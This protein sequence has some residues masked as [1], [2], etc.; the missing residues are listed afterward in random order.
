MP[1]RNKTLVIKDPAIVRALRTPVR[2]EVLAAL[3]A[4][5][6]GSVKDIAGEL[7]RAPA[8]LY[9]H[10][11]ALA[12]AGLIRQTG[13]RPSAR[14]DE[15]VY[16]PAAARIIIDRRGTSRA[17]IEALADLHSSALRTAEREM[18][19]SLKQ[20]SAN[21]TP[22]GDSVALLR[23]TARLKPGD[24][25]A[26]RRKLEEVARFLAERDDPDAATS[27]AFTATFAELVSSS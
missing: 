25:R 7:G 8:S 10:V 23:L 4:L 2:Q 20:K 17:F 5:G 12:E 14:R 1:R 26:A 3:E 22:P 13:T 27:Y 6:E 11:H 24:I 19:A 9:Y 18:R 16:E 15:A 21:G